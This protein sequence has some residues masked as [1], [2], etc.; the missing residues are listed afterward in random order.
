MHRID[1]DQQKRR[2]ENEKIRLKLLAAQSAS[3]A[4]IR[5][6]ELFHAI[7]SIYQEDPIYIAWE[8]VKNE[9]APS[10]PIFSATEEEAAK[11]KL[12]HFRPSW[13]DK[14][15]GYSRKVK[16]LKKEIIQSAANDQKRYADALKEHEQY[17]E[18]WKILQ[19]ISEGVLAR[20]PDFYEAATDYFQLFAD[21]AGLGSGLSMVFN[22]ASA[23]ADL[24]VF[25]TDL[26]PGYILSKTAGGKLSRKNMPNS[27][28]NHLYQ[29]YVCSA[30][31][32]VARDILGL[33]PLDG[34]VV[35]AMSNRLNTAT[36]KIENQIL[37]SVLFYPHI[38]NELNFDAIKPVD[39]M[40]N[41]LHHMKC[42]QSVGFAPVEKIDV[43]TIRQ[44]DNR[45][46]K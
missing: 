1:K 2:R 39:A 32:R 33:L 22:K 24:H 20:K 34:L 27:K 38:L 12:E 31:L 25:G 15:I 46:A 8:D 14:I 45:K 35:N 40:R 7:T 17:L 23:T 43:D 10:Q 42:T 37:L 28:L 13:F 30:T 16:K 44:P 11:N 21:T 41:F 3:E 6:E 4:I 9:L 19:R 36:G 29:D 18:E 26:I 5:Q